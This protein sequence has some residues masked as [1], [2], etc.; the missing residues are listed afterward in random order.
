MTAGKGLQSVATTS[1]SGIR[2]PRNRILRP[3]C[4]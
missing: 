4:P 1:H 3:A 2:G